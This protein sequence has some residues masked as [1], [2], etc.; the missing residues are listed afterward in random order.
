MKGENVKNLDMMRYSSKIPK[1][2]TPKNGNIQGVCEHIKA[3]IDFISK[4]AK[5]M[6]DVERLRS[7]H[8]LQELKQILSTI[9]DIDHSVDSLLKKQWKRRAS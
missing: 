3:D 1:E 4:E 2:K 6:D 9:E 8:R 5:Y 7:L